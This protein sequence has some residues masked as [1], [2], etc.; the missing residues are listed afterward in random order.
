M[1]DLIVVEKIAQWQRLKALVLDSVSSPITKRVYNMAGR[2]YDL[3]PAGTAARLHQGHRSIK[4]PSSK[5][6]KNWLSVIALCMTSSSASIGRLGAG[7]TD[8][9]VNSTSPPYRI[10]R[11][12][13]LPT[14]AFKRETVSIKRFYDV[15][16]TS[17]SPTCD[18]VFPIKT[19]GY[20]R[21]TLEE[22]S[23]GTYA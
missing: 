8:K 6:T 18:N 16:W 17:A 5:R 15:F 21:R 20:F 4:V 7:S 11:S 19:H 9:N 1:N 3:V 13:C 22:P 14:R 23:S 12:P 10:L 2:I